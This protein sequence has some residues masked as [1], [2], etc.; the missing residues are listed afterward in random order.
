MTHA[1]ASGRPAC[2]S[3]REDFRRY[4]DSDI[5]ALREEKVPGYRIHRP[6]GKGGMASV[7][8]ATDDSGF[9]VAL[10][11]VPDHPP[12]HP[13]RHVREW[14]LRECAATLAIA[15]PNVINSY[16][17]GVSRGYLY[18]SL[19]I[20]SGMSLSKFLRENGRLAW[21]E[22]RRI[23]LDVC[24]GLHAAHE[25]GVVHRDVKPENVMLER[26]GGGA[27][28]KI[29]DFG[30]CHMD[31]Y[32]DIYPFIKD[33]PGIAAPRVTPANG[34]FG[35]PEF[36]PPEFDSPGAGS[37]RSFDIYSAGVMFYEALS[38]RLPFLAP[39]ASDRQEA[40]RTYAILHKNHHPWKPSVYAP[41]LPP[42]VDRAI[43]RALEKDPAGR[44]RDMMEMKAA[45]EAC[46]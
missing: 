25:A 24:D 41:G 10:K 20:V 36:R 14:F 43:L 1:Q 26:S 44:F 13:L 11:L 7:F 16:E 40:A 12:G 8:L 37:R 15:H 23:F 39:D 28:A 9:A 31:G 38:G 19:E 42:E 21:P 22:A 45:F 2:Q 18:L 32:E 30:L 6:L 4:H 27:T 17:G 33:V 46:P 3:W 29:I 35:T 5:S 34:Q